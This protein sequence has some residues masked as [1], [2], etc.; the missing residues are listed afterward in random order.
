MLDAWRMKDFDRDAGLASGAERPE[1]D[2]SG[3]IPVPAP[4]DAYL[5]LHEA[6]RGQHPFEEGAEE[7]LRWVIDREWWWRTTFDAEPAVAGERLILT[8]HGLDT[9]AEIWLNG[10]RLGASDNMFVAVPFDVTDR[11]EAGLN[12]LAIR[13]DPVAAR[14][15]DLTAPVWSEVNNPVFS[16]KRNLVR[17]AQFGWGWDWGPVL[18]TVGIWRPVTLER[19]SVAA[20]KDVVFQTLEI[21]PDASRAQVR[22]IVE[23][24]QFAGSPALTAEISLANPSGRIV[25]R[26]ALTPGVGL[27]SASLDFEIVGPQLW[28]TA[29]LGEPDLHALKVTLK[30]GDTVLDTREEAVGVRT[31]ALDTS[32]DPDEPGTEFFRFVLNGRPLFSKGVCWIPASSMV[33]ALTEADYRPLLEG[34]VAAN[35][36]MLRVWGG[37][38]YE[39]DAFYALCDELGLLVW[40]DFMFACSP[41]PEDDPAFVDSVKAEIA[42]QTRRLRNR[43]CVALWCGNNEN[44][45]IQNLIDAFSGEPKYLPGTIYYDEIIPEIV[46]ALDPTRAYWPGSP[47]GG[48]HA[49]SM[50]FGDV[51]DWTVW[52]GGPPVPDDRPTSMPDHS[53]AG[54]AY[55]RYAEDMGRFISEF[56]IQAAPVMETLK[57]CLPADQLTLNSPGVLNRIK[58]NPK[59]KI[60]PMMIPVA[61]TPTT[62]EEYV[63][64]SMILQAEGLKFGIEHFRRRTPHC[65][66]A[67][68]W[69]HNDCWPGVSWS[70]VDH[71]GFEKAGYFYVKRAYAP[72]MASFKPLN[73]GG[74]ELWLTN[75]GDAPFT[76]DLT[77]ELIDMIS[78]VGW[79]ETWAV[80]TPGAD[81]RVVWSADAARLGASPSRVLTVR[82]MKAD[83]PPNRFFFSQIKDLV[84]PKDVAPE[85]RIEQPDPHTLVVSLTAPA[86]LY[87]VQ[88][89]L[90]SETARFSDNYFDLAAGQ[91]HVVTITDPVRRLDLDALTVRSV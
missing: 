9:F 29:E 53:P 25:A 88:L 91:T 45:F 41:Y 47:W 74:I 46:K 60:D 22:I 23:T 1:V 59:N 72:V 78:G 12:V 26:G 17:K 28:W 49:N 39:H 89:L 52:H 56:G 75:D 18:P 80:S 32:P 65:S 8:F 86:Y 15:A 54:V 3:W 58:D 43:P 33:G 66:G 51:H 5:A 90:P 30:D 36:N 38:I 16:N 31:I 67:L 4:G 57:R 61:G 50:R 77:V 79:S 71:Y 14:L 2:E 27:A 44:Q 87:F 40:Q 13:F 20:I 48:A 7:S 11:V 76:D 10:E 63:D 34:A 70:L 21:A 85:V 81:S 6:G 42:Y 82:A 64:F 35:M 62:L 55:Q 69:Q 19:Q 84:R 83:V 24:E 73:D 37:G 68:I